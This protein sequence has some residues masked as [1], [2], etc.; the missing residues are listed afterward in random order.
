M[1]TGEYDRLIA[2]EAA[3]WGDVAQDPENPQ[4]WD[5][6]ELFEIF[7][8]VEFRMLLGEVQECGSRVLELGCGAGGL[9]LRLAELGKTVTGIDLS[10][11]R[12]RRAGDEARRRGLESR[13]SFLAGDLNVMPLPGNSFDC[14]VA[15]DALHHV[16]EL[17]GLLDR[18][19]A[20]LIP[21]G[22]VIV[23][24]FVGMGPVRKVAAAAM[25]ALLPT[26]QSYR[27]KWSLRHR[28]G[29]FLA[30]ERAK[31]RAIERGRADR[32]HAG[33]PFEE[34]SGRSIPEEIRRRFRVLEEHTFCPF[35]YYL[36]PKI[37]LPRRLRRAAAL[38][39]HTLDALALR[40]RPSS[41]AYILMIARHDRPD[42]I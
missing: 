16:L 2:R 15:H 27:V 13:T 31:R 35:W 39:L 12:I 36:A 18:V 26:H 6:P 8:G 28:V 38:G 37:R 9:A 40:L 1:N 17:G 41:G 10:P 25:Y 23:M 7:F 14:V 33:S 5:D 20:A 3:H 19:R 29:A 30:S 22:R 42:T 11:E 34:I 4:I 24:D 21:G 32:L